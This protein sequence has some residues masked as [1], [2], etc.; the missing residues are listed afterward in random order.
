MLQQAGRQRRRDG[1]APA[2]RARHFPDALWFVLLGV[3]GLAGVLAFRYFDVPVAQRMDGLFGLAVRVGSGLTGAALLAVEAAVALGLVG[4][5]LKRGQLPPAGEALALACL[6]SIVAYAVNDAILK[7]F[8]GVPNP[9][10]VLQGSRHAFDLLEGTASSSFPSGHMVLAG[11]FAG[12]FMRLYRASV[13]PLAGLLT[14]AAVLLIAG[15]WHFVSDVIAGG[16]LG[17]SA[18][19]T[20]GELWIAHLKRLAGR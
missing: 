19:L 2:A 5:R 8:F 4:V 11:A 7:L 18:G 10:A 12:V 3:C 17:I 16:F 6:T 20:A 1:Y 9:A 13:A 15:D 14:L